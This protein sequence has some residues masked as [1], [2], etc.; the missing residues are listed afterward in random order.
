[1]T[2]P[3]IRGQLGED[4]ARQYLEAQGLRYLSRNWQSK[5]GEID[6]IMQDG[7]VRV[8]VEVRLRSQTTFGSG[9]DTVSWQKQRKL[10]RTAKFYQQKNRYWGDLRFDVISITYLAD[11]PPEIIHVPSAFMAS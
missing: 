3:Q 4:L 8:F 11:T 10:I 5:F 9:L 2:L 7:E 1:M 6:L